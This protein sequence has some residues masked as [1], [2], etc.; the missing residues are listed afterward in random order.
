MK[1]FTYVILWGVV[2]ICSLPMLGIVWSSWFASKHGC[3]LNEAGYHPCIVNGSDWGHS[4]GA[5]F[6]GG[7]Y[8]LI[9]FPI[10][11]AIFLVIVTMMV[12]GL[13]KKR[14]ERKA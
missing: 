3:T 10:G 4:L 8:G 9:T 2:L 5:A 1:R 11:L 7:W 12:F 13:I 14:R 6:V